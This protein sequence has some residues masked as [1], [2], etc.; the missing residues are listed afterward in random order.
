MML[1]PP[2]DTSP[3]WPTR[4]KRT[5]HQVTNGTVVAAAT[6][7]EDWIRLHCVLECF[8]C[9]ENSSQYSIG[10]STIKNR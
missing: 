10:Q 7:K 1:I 8:A 4:N 9:K 6:P 2:K 5:V 3:Q